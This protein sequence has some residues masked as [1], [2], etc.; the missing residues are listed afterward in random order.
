MRAKTLTTRMN[1]VLSPMDHE[2]IKT[3]A[4]LHG[5]S[6]SFFV[7]HFSVLQSKVIIDQHE[8]KTKLKRIA[9]IIEQRKHRHKE[10]AIA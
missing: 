6:M 10:G 9:D 1:L 5:C 2:L 8:E 7:R 4:K 3:A